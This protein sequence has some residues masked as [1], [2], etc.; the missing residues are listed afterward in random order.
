MN[1]TTIAAGADDRFE[2]N[3]TGATAAN[4]GSLI[5][6]NTFEDLVLNAGDDDYFRFTT[7]ATGQ[8]GDFV[9]IRFDHAA[10]DL[11]LALYNAA[12]TFVV[13]SAGSTGDES[14][15]LAGLAAGQYSVRVYGFG[16]AANPSYDLVV[17]A[18]T[19]LA[20]DRFEENDT[21]ATATDL[22]AATALGVIDGLVI[23][24]GDSDFFRF[25]LPAPTG[26]NQVQVTFDHTLGDVDLRL[27]NAEG[28]LVGGSAGVTGTESLDLGDFAAG[29]YTLEVFGFAGAANPDYQLLFD[30]AAAD[31]TPLDD[32]YEENDTQDQAADL[33]TLSGSGRRFA[34]LVSLPTDFDWYSFTTT[35][36]RVGDAVRI[37]FADSVSDLDMVLY[38]DA[39]N[40]VGSSL[41]VT[42]EEIISLLNLA[43]G[44]YRIGVYSFDDA[45]PNRY[46][47]VV[48]APVAPP[49]AELDDR[50]EEND[51]PFT[52]FDV[53]SLSLSRAPTLVTTTLSN[54][55]ARDDDWFTFRLPETGQASD[56]VRLRFTHALGDLDLELYQAVEPLTEGTTLDD[57]SLI[58][59][60]VSITDNEYISLDG[61]AAGQYLARVFG[62]AGATNLYDLIIQTT[63]DLADDRFESNET[64]S[65]AAALRVLEGTEN[66][67]DGLNILTGD[68]D[69]FSFTTE[70]TG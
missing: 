36:R 10:G 62:Y 20:D 5:G 18:P 41:G 70:A 65:T 58:D 16:D 8:D 24:S 40:L 67:F 46:D 13:G 38:D 28:E 25:T 17:E 44:T 37:T 2:E 7:A 19:V 60:S 26:G 30:V 27:F 50:Y 14:I 9:S 33:G 11:D 68:V 69:W 21:F 32:R 54:G 15:S 57:L 35:P 56:G 43:A 3:D 61:L 47:L 52:A 55:I 63:Q 66:R 31:P 12:G 1:F 34:D 39:G 4:L 48:D 49:S 23:R 64:R 42:D 29:A 53:N 45:A 59:S 6:T 51:T 22:G